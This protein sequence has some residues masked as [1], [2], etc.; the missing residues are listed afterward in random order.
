MKEEFALSF[1]Q[2]GSITLVYQLT[3]GFIQPFVGRFADKHPTPY[4]LP[5]GMLFTITGLFTVAFAGHYAMVL[6]GVC[7]L[8]LGTS[9]FHLKAVFV[10]QCA[11]G[12]R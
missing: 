4:A 7:L 3:A 1:A 12:A 8:G 6:I 9:I 10:V 11:A 2:V 5:A